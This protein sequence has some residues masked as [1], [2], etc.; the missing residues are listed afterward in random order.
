MVAA[1]LVA[2]GL[3][4]AGIAA[5]LGVGR[6]SSTRATDADGHL[7]RVRQQI[8]YQP[9][10]LLAAGALAGVS[11]CFVEG[12]GVL[13]LGDLGAPARD[14]TWLGFAPGETWNSVGVTF[15]VV[16][17][18]VTTVVVYLQVLRG[19]PVRFAE[20]LWA[21]AW[22]LP[23]SVMNALTEE[24]IFRV[25]VVHA[26]AG[27]VGADVIAVASGLAFGLPHYVGTPGRVPGVLMA[28]ALGWIMARAVLETNGLGW[29]WA[30][31]FV[32]DVPILTMM[33]LAARS[34]Q[35]ALAPPT[36]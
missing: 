2:L 10:T 4:A 1:W 28:G 32:Q 14:L 20:L 35:T 3:V 23:F 5:L 16:P 31:H 19:K 25:G 7:D 27:H 34:A 33:I 29:A 13:R 18:L 8:L 24:L 12:P 36:P 9:I 26:L 21:L 30:I 6:Y 22:A 11:W 15:C 17:F